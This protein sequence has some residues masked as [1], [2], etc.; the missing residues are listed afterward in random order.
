MFRQAERH[1]LLHRVFGADFG[2]C[3][4]ASAAFT[5]LDNAAKAAVA[6][7]FT[8]TSLTELTDVFNQI[9]AQGHQDQTTF[10]RSRGGGQRV[11]SHANAE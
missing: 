5:Y 3:R 2:H 8:A 6:T 11:Q 7:P 4:R 10:F 9:F 1:E